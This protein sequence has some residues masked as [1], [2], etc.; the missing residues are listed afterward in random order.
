MPFVF[1]VCFV[2]HSE[3]DVSTNL[4]VSVLGKRPEKEPS[5]GRRVIDLSPEALKLARPPR[6]YP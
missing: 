2:G 4:L 6:F 3:P 1:L 5:Q